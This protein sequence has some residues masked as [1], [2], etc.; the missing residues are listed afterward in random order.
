MHLI[1]VHGRCPAAPHQPLY[2]QHPIDRRHDV[3]TSCGCFLL[4]SEMEKTVTVKS[5]SATYFC[6]TAALRPQLECLVL[7]YCSLPLSCP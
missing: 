3:V 5:A 1:L 4:A 7:L 2:I 6:S